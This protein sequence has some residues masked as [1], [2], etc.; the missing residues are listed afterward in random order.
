MNLILCM[1]GLYR[2]FRDA[3]Y[4]QPK[5]LLPWQGDVIIGHILEE[6]LQDGAF[7][8]LLLVANRRD[9]AH[10]AALASIVARHGYSERNL[11]FID[12]TRGQAETA[13]LGAHYVMDELQPADQRLAFHNIDTIL[14]GRDYHRI[15]EAL[16]TA[17]GYIDVF[18]ADSPAYSY[19]T[20]DDAYRV[21]DIAEKVVI[22]NHAT[23]GFYGFRTPQLYAQWAQQSEWRN[24]FY[25]SD[26]YKRMLNA[27]APLTINPDSDGHRTLIL[28]T[29][30]EYEAACAAP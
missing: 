6:M 18:P 11:I 26:V 25:I 1:A 29:P 23:T 20:V 10:R 14:Y 4:E 21:T 2:R 3:G 16:T 8:N 9:A 22:S 13:L 12:D 7:D 27:G 5:F 24:E 28:G 17:D 30:A 15:A 19:V